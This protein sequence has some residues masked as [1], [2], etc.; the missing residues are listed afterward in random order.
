MI[1]NDAICIVTAEIRLSHPLQFE[2]ALD[3]PLVAV[4]TSRLLEDVTSTK[5]L[6]GAA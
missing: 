5:Q 3:E 2:G 4:S 1:S 6:W